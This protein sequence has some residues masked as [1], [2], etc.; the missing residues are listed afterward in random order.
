MDVITTL[1][2][3]EALNPLWA[4]GWVFAAVPLSIF[5]LLGFVL[6]T[7]RDVANRH[8]H[9]TGKGSGHGGHH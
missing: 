2:A 6:Y 8:S 1:A 5:F 3:E 9:K 7:Y 4:P